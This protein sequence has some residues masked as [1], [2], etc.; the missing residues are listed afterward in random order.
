MS[1]KTSIDFNIHSDLFWLRVAD[2]SVWGLIEN[3]PAIIEVTVP[4]YST[5]IVKY[6]DKSKTN[7]FNS[8]ILELNC[9]GDCKGV[10][11]VALPD[12]IYEIT[13]KGSPDTF[14]KTYHY[15]KTDALQIDIDK[16]IVDS[17]D[18]GCIQDVQDK[19]TE[20]EMLVAGAESHIRHD[21]ISMA[22]NMF[23][24]AIDRVDKLKDCKTC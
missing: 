21:L 7:G 8:L 5:K 20:I 11:K 16:V 24:K 12:G 2:Y 14:Q 4:G 15:L 3:K 19:L 22:G 9:S 1:T 23:Q 17:Y 6:F 18:E 13:V 10:D